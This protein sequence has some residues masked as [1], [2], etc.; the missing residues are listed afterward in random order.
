[1]NSLKRRRIFIIAPQRDGDTIYRICTHRG[2]RSALEA[3]QLDEYEELATKTSMEAARKVA[4]HHGGK[5]A[6]VI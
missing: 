6:K 1:M 3:Y 5:R 2:V 4:R